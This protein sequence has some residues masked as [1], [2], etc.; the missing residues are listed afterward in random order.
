[1]VALSQGLLS[2]F[3]NC[4]TLITKYSPPWLRHYAD[5]RPGNGVGWDTGSFFCVHLHKKDFDL[6]QV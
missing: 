6:L 3:R 2:E 4:K 1:M 5:K